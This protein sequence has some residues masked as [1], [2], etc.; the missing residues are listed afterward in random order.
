M[1]MIRF[2]ERVISL[3]IDGKVEICTLSPADSTKRC[4]VSKSSG[5]KRKP[6]LD[7]TAEQAVAV[8]KRMEKEIYSSDQNLL[9]RRVKEELITDY[10]L[11]QQKM[12]QFVCRVY[13]LTDTALF[14][15]QQKLLRKPTALQQK[16]VQPYQLHLPHLPHLRYR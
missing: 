3:D 9:E 11:C 16:R 2:N 4:L 7:Y 8:A 5:K 13:R 14:L 15:L 12:V 6:R 10:L 1:G